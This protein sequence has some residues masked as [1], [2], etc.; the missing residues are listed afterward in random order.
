[1]RTPSTRSKRT[2]QS[3]GLPFLRISAVTGEGLAEL[4]EAM[5][6]YLTPI[7]E[8]EARHHEAEVVLD[9]PLRR[10]ATPPNP[11]AKQRR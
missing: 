4:Q 9:A 1:M 5:W 10:D 8:A 3:R 11:S 7:A 6:K 2:S